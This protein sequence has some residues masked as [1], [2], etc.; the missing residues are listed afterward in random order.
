VWYTKNVKQTRRTT[1]VTLPPDAKASILKPNAAPVFH[2]QGDI[3]WACASCATVLVEGVE[4][5]Q[6]Q[7]VYIICP[8]CGKTSALV[9]TH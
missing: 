3:D 7:D 6:I 8:S 2:G 9:E 1:I 4:E 5:G